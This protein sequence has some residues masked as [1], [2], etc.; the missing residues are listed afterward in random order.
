ME[1]ELERVYQQALD[2]GIEE[3]FIAE[4]MCNNIEEVSV[5]DILKFIYKKWGVEVSYERYI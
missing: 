5:D 1:R 4:Y 3:D 2:D